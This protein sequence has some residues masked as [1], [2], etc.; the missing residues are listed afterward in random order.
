[1]ELS[2]ADA[3]RAGFGRAVIVTRSALLEELK[4]SLARADR[5][6]DLR[7]ALQDASDPARAKPW[8]TGHAVLCARSEIEGPFGVANAD[9][10]YGADAWH[11]LATGVSD[12]A[13]GRAA[14]AGALVTFR[15]DATLSPHG[16]VNRGVCELTESGAT[17]V[18]IEEVTGIRWVPG[19][20]GLEGVAEDG[21][22]RRLS[23]GEP[24]SLNLWAFGTEVF[25]SLGEGFEAFRHHAG[26]DDE[27]LLPAQVDALIGRRAIRVRVYPTPSQWVG[28]THREDVGP[29]RAAIA[30]AF[31][32]GRYDSP[33]FPE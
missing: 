22:A 19:S 12:I 9:D 8:G 4:R 28:V 26:A 2:L 27:F 23:G 14:L 25:R 30:A 11:R 17:L 5:A 6:M 16:G 1:M 7:F 21:T 20:P 29:V 31:A 18:R 24:V 33:L 13:K 3:V 15:L 10:L 32:A